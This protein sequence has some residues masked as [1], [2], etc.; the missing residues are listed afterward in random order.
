M[1]S[2]TYKQRNED[3]RRIFKGLPEAERL[4]VGEIQEMGWVDV[5]GSDERGGTVGGG[6][7]NVSLGCLEHLADCW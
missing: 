4:L 5:E 3:F 1:L 2:P 6:S 7:Q